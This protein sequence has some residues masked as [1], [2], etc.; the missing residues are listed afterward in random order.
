MNRLPVY[1]FLFAALLRGSAFAST[2]QWIEARSQHFTVLSDAN[3][4]QARHILDQ[5]ERMRWMFQT[6][7][8]KANVDPIEPIVV[9]AAKNQHTFEAMEPAAYL[10][11]GQLKLGGYFLSIT[12][13]NYVL[14]NLD[15][16]SE[17]PYATVYHEY[18]HLQ[19][20]ADL[21]WMPLWLNEGLAEFI[22]NTDIRDK[23]V[24]LGQPSTDDILYLRQNRLIPLAVLLGVDSQ[25]PY[26]H[27][28]QKGSVFY[29]ESWALTHY[30]EITDSQKGTKMLSRYIDLVSQGEDS[31]TAGEKAFGD[32]GKLQKALDSYIQA[33]SYRQ[34]VLSSAAAPIDESAYKVTPIARIQADAARADVL[35]HVQRQG[36]ARTLLD[37]LLKADPDNAQVHETM[38]SLEL[39]ADHREEARNWYEQ[40]VNLDS[41]NYL[42]HYYFASLSMG[43]IREDDAAIE[44]SLRTA[45]RLN[46]RFAP[47]YDRLAS[48]LATKRQKLDEAHMLNLQAIALDPGNLNYRMNAANVFMSQDRYPDALNA[49]RIAQK[50]AR[51]PAETAK[52]E[53]EMKQV[54][55]F[56]Q[57]RSEAETNVKRIAAEQVRAVNQT[58]TVVA[59][60]PMHPTEPPNGPKHTVEGVIQNVSCGYPSVLE[61]SVVNAKTTAS[62]YINDFFKLEVTASGFTPSGSLNPCHDLQGMKAHVQY[63]ESSD[64]TIDG[65]VIAVEL[66]K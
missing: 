45:I 1:L 37:E 25:S 63:A 16:Q 42:A 17:H 31:A 2:D 46:P 55:Q 51:N 61:F 10:G 22:Q 66:E 32:L 48:F 50:V 14:L 21:A 27:Q 26:Y 39:A 47:A 11:K 36:E 34:F 44:A 23:D 18:T 6:L 19:F 59:L 53:E 54:E 38:G 13:K 60:P 52:V 4:K 43:S 35:A 41:Q 49:L 33:S 29:A 40:A 58:P 56:L 9:L 28:E 5:F 65:Q 62:L 8:P 3:E 15:A 20:K 30:L 57:A 64:K 7:F 24:L 12:D